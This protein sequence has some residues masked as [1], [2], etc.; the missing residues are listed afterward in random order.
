MVFHWSLS[1][2]KSLQV[3]KTLLSILAN[4]SNLIV[5]VASPH[6]LIFKSSCPKNYS[7]MTL[8]ST[9]ITIGINVTLMFHSSFSS[10]AKSWYLSLFSFSFSFTLWSAGTAKSTIRQVLFFV[11]YPKLEDPFCLKI[12]KNFVRLIFSGGFWV[13]HVFV[14]D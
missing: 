4:L 1:D 9:P 6:P 8:L 5:W 7:L 10:L 3:F 11:V 13:V 2:S 14:R 12:P